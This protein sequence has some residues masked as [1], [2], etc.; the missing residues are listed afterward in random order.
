M[1]KLKQLI[2]GLLFPAVIFSCKKT[3]IVP[4]SELAQQ[5]NSSANK[6]VYLSGFY[7]SN[8]DIAHAAYWKNG[9]LHA[10][11][12][13]DSDSYALRIAMLQDH[14]V[15]VGES[16]GQPMLWIDSQS[17][18]LVDVTQTGEASSV[19]IK[20]DK[21]F[22]CGTVY[23][24]D[25]D[26]SQRA[27]LWIVDSQ[28]SI[29]ERQTLESVPSRALDLKFD[30]D[31]LY[32]AGSIGDLTGKPCY[33][34]L[35]GSSSYASQTRT[36]LDK[37]NL[38]MALAIEI[39]Q[40]KVFCTGILDNGALGGYSGT[41][42]GSVFINGYWTNTAFDASTLLSNQAIFSDLAIA[43]DGTVYQ[44][45]V[46]HDQNDLGQAMLW[47]GSNFVSQQLS[48][49]YSSASKI[50][51]EGKDVFIVGQ[52]NGSACYWENGS[53][54]SLVLPNSNATDVMLVAK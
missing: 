41:G 34:K 9:E 54:H 22:I 23:D 45:G 16:G 47:K 19:Q 24:D 36:E 10:L 26:G 33:W 20:D 43:S 39:F 6:D 13:D 40:G 31:D 51:V 1:K 15:L 14:V 53:L 21:L 32:I 49:K 5:L 48:E 30:G 7:Y 29:L 3:E 38:G 25:Q 37:S 8:D 46:Q 50:K 52:E 18:P 4:E 42:S 44:V 17:I 27:A 28:G 11:G 12:N 2:I 35:S